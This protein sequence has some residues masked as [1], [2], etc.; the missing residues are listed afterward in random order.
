MR[1]DRIL[2]GVG[3][4]RLVVGPRRQMVLE[5][6]SFRISAKSWF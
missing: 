3:I 4:N 6:K 1:L 5:I 2:T